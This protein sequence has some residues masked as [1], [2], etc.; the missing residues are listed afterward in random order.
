ME[1]FGERL[2]SLRRRVRVDIDREGF[3]RERVLAVMLRLI[4]QPWFRVGAEN[5]VQ[6]YRAYGVTTPRNRHLRAE[7][8]GRLVFRSVGKH[9]V[10][11]RLVMVDDEVASLVIAVRDLRG[12]HRFACMKDAVRVLS[13]TP[14]DANSYIKGPTGSR[15]G[16]GTSVQGEVRCWP[17]WR[18]PRAARPTIRRW[19]TGPSASPSRR[20]PDGSA[21]RRP[22][23]RPATFTRPCWR[24]TGARSTIGAC[25]RREERGGAA[26]RGCRWRE[27]LCWRCSA[28]AVSGRKRPRRHRPDEPGG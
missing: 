14:A 10:A 15:S 17:P 19:R 13:V 28:P 24:R 26:S 16:R 11:Q 8:G 25:R 22:S 12:S 20:R 3:L 23:A 9:H 27:R 2:P 6:R 7:P 5:S 1:R 18:T 4:G 21:R